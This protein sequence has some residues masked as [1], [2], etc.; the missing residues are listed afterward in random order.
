MLQLALH[1]LLAA[2]PLETR[3]R[4]PEGFDLAH[5]VDEGGLNFTLSDG[6]LTLELLLDPETA[7]HL[8]ETPL[9]QDQVMEDTADGCVWL[10][11]T[12]A[13]TAQV[14]WWLL[15]LGDQVE[16]ISPQ[17]LRETIATTL[18]QAAARYD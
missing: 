9:S 16:V 4:R 10:T 6:S 11:A 17:S 5:Y 14:R 15:G 2:E 18:R 8:R 13:D 7:F 12:V 1:R 3:A